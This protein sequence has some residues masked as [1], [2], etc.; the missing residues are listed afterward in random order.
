MI[1]SFYSY[2]GGVGRSQL[3]VNIAAYLCHK[4]LKKVLLWDWDFEAPGLHSFFEKNSRCISV[5]GTIEMLESYVSLMRSNPEVR[6][7]DLSYFEESSILSL[8]KSEIIE[9]EFGKIDLIPAGNYSDNFSFKI[10][11]FNWYEFYE[12]LDGVNY[13]EQLKNWLNNREYDYVLIDSRTGITDYSGICNI[14]L[15]DT[16]VVLM[17]A[18]E[19][20]FQGCKNIIN[21]ILNSDY[22]KLGYRKKYIFPILSRIDSSHLEYEKWL[23]KFRFSFSE[24]LTNIDSSID[25]VFLDDIF[26][27]FYL[28][29]TLLEYTPAYSAGENM[30]ISSFDQVISRSSFISKYVNIA[31]YLLSIDANQTIDIFKQISKDTWAKYAERSKQTNNNI[32]TALAYT[33]ANEIDMAIEYGGTNTAFYIKGN[34]C[35]LK[36]KYR[37]AIDF[38][39]KALELNNDDYLSCANIGN[40]YFA[41]KEY[42]KAIIYYQKSLDFKPD[43]LLAI[44]KLGNA[45]AK[46]SEYNK[47]ISCYNKFLAYK[48]NSFEA[49]Y[50]LGRALCDAGE[51][52]HAIDQYL[53]LLEFVPNKYEVLLALG[54]SYNKKNDYSNAVAFFKKALEFKPDDPIALFSYNM[55]LFNGNNYESAIVGF[56]KYLE[57]NPNS[58]PT[59]LNL[60]NS[61]AYLHLY[62][63]AIFFYKKS[64]EIKPNSFSAL[65]NL[66]NLFFNTRE[67]NSAIIYYHQ[68]LN[69]KPDSSTVHNYLGLLY[70]ETGEFDLSYTYLTRSL[71][72]A[73]SNYDTIVYLIYICI[74]RGEID[75]AKILLSKVD[76]INN[77]KASYLLTGHIAFLEDKIEDAVFYYKASLS[78]FNDINLFLKFADDFMVPLKLKGI[79]KDTFLA[80][81]S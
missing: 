5:P 66:G 6:P 12:L 34:D 36:G 38:Y 62:E 33:F 40:S 52:D 27:D 44:G 25:P 30:L 13:I 79:T 70:I 31:E 35:F 14:Q 7:D 28:N 23:E 65:L 21:Q 60:G 41:L 74:I 4:K 42:D 73:P 63:D 53:I 22:T 37:Q 29:N 8:D 78:L 19:Q 43:Y 48:P 58:F 67:F 47:A 15:P 51:F 75:N 24:L 2:K 77:S 80:L 59:L 45:F 20:N 69:V 61:Y 71:I 26:K 3:C 16:N 39:T 1:I 11:N 56:K 81:I 68:A 18:N 55:A 72:I 76:D 64:L 50:N 57:I 49:R 17:A 9:N 10:N 32:K 46:I 54:K